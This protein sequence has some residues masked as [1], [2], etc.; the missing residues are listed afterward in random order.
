MVNADI[1]GR[2]G[3]SGQWQYHSPLASDLGAL[4]P[5]CLQMGRVEGLGYD[6]GWH[7]HSRACASSAI[8]P[9]AA[10]AY[11][12]SQ[13]RFPWWRRLPEAR[14]DTAMP[15]PHSASFPDTDPSH[16]AACKAC[17]WALQYGIEYR[18]AWSR[19]R[20]RAVPGFR[21]RG[22][23]SIPGIVPGYIMDGNGET[24]ITRDK[25]NPS[26]QGCMG[27]LLSA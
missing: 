2:C 21:E 6:A 19:L 22:F 24:R 15:L 23:D 3:S 18:S 12:Q 8:S 7:S 1:G 20:I 11:S 17:P 14:N 16:Q 25:K 9:L 4:K 10:Y 26:S 27:V 5:G 13:T